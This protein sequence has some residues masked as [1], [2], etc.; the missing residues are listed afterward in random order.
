MDADKAYQ[1]SRA[2]GR[3]AKVAAEAER[4]LLRGWPGGWTKPPTSVQARHIVI[5]HDT[6]GPLTDLG[7]DAR[8]E[9]AGK[10]VHECA[11]SDLV[12]MF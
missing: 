3:I 6:L 11:V 12:E 2:L 8:W 1:V 7:D 4:T 5:V 9:I 10:L